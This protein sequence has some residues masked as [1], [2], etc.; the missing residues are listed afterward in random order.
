LTS[1]GDLTGFPRCQDYGSTKAG[2][3][4]FTRSLV[5]EVADKGIIDNSI[6][7]GIIRTRAYNQLSKEVI[8]HVF[9]GINASH[10][11]EPEDIFDAVTFLSSNKAAM[12]LDR[13][14]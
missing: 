9:S 11:A 13:P 3:I 10:V 12:L 1:K 7:P 4:G 14:Y 5:Q 6:S 2:V 8:H